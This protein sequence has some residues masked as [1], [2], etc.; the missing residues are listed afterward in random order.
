MSGGGG[1]TGK[2]QEALGETAGG[3]SQGEEKRKGRML[4]L[5]KGGGG[6]VTGRT[7]HV[8]A[9]EGKGKALE[10]DNPAPF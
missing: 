6:R 8:P 2:V 3:T 4:G 5:R 9:W 7:P 10:M 1:K